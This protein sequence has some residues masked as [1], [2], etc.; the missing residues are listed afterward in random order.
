MRSRTCEWNECFAMLWT[1]RPSTVVSS[2]LPPI[3]KVTMSRSSAWSFALIGALLVAAAHDAMAQQRPSPEISQAKLNI[4]T[5]IYQKLRYRYVG[6][7]GNR[8]T[9][10][11]GVPGN[12]DVYYAGAASGG[13]FK[14][15]DGGV[16]WTS[17][18]DDQPV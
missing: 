2:F 9:S 1:T 8:I 15:T 17:I 10:I 11:A 18:F 12:P 6:P 13:I 4:D 16:H 7:E 5:T 3:I 14:S